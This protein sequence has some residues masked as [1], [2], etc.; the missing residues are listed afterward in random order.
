MGELQNAL[1][2]ALLLRRDAG[3]TATFV[4]AAEFIGSAASVGFSE[5]V[6]PGRVVSGS[7]W[8]RAVVEDIK[9]SLI[10]LA[11]HA[12]LAL[13]RTSFVATDVYDTG[14][15]TLALD[16]LQ[17]APGPRE[18]TFAISAMPESAR[19]RRWLPE[20]VTV[21]EVPADVPV[22]TPVPVASPRCAINPFGVYEP[23]GPSHPSTTDWR[24]RLGVE[25]SGKLV[26]SA[27]SGWAAQ[28]FDLMSRGRG[29]TASYSELRLRRITRSLQVVSPRAVIVEVGGRHQGDFNGIRVVSVP[30]LDPREFTGLLAAAD[31]FLNDNLISGALAQASL[32]G[33]PSLTLVNSRRYY[34]TPGDELDAKMSSSF[35]DWGF[36][37]VVNP[38]GWVEELEPVLE[39]NPY[40]AG[41]VRAEIYQRSNLEARFAQQL[42]ARPD[43]TAA[44]ELAA[45][46]QTLPRAVDVFANL[47]AAF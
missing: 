5:R 24:D 6:V 25:T 17:F 36:P 33:I 19:M 4:I 35:T 20:R 47:V 26:L 42:S 11:D 23:G 45:T 34:P 15:P 46:L 40:L 29:N 39:Q 22:A 44:E 32:L 8:F 31:L 10:I 13:E 18:V 27:Q 3:T 12:N 2:L 7:R 21:P 1:R 38:L 16:S 14:I 43:L 9:P 28:M 30:K 37:F 41:L